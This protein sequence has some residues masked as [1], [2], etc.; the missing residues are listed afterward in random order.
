MVTCS[1]CCWSV[2]ANKHTFDCLNYMI[3]DTFGHA[4]K[5]YSWG[6]KTCNEWSRCLCVFF[7]FAKLRGSSDAD[8]ACPLLIPSTSRWLWFLLRFA[9]VLHSPWLASNSLRPYSPTSSKMITH[10]PWPEQR[11]YSICTNHTHWLMPRKHGNCFV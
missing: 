7:W 8:F 2:G 11:R 1:D 9:V 3:V 5:A 4:F 6:A 10:P